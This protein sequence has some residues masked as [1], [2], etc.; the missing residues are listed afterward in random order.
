[1]KEVIAAVNQTPQLFE[2]NC[3]LY[4]KWDSYKTST[5][6]NN[7]VATSSDVRFLAEFGH[8]ESKWIILFSLMLA[9]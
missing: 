6:P 8:R 7:M 5:L 4:V 3:F 1:M 2:S 9:T